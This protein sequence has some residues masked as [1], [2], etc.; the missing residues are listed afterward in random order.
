[1]KK[2]FWVGKVRG[3]REVE[4]PGKAWG[5]FPVPLNHGAEIS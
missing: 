3:E 1:M 2:P 4:G 5:G